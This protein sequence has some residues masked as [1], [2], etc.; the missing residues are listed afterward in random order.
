MDDCFIS[1]VCIPKIE[2]CKILNFKIL[3]CLYI[4]YN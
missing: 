3:K 1:T 4:G 2:K